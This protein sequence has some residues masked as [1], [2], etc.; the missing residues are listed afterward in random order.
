MSDAL[1]PYEK[2]YVASKA[3][4]SFLGATFHIDTP[5]GEPAF[6]VKQKAFRLRE[7]IEVFRDSSK[8]DKRL[9][10]QA[11]SISDFSS[12]YDVVDPETGESVGGAKRH[13]F[14]S[15]FQDE[16]SLL[17]ETGEVR[18]KCVER[19]GLMIVLRK[20]MPIIPQTYELSWDGQVVGHVRQRFHPFRLIY[21][22][23]FENLGTFDVRHGIGMVV[24]L[25]AI[26]SERD[27]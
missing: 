16:W 6:W 23:E 3:L 5:G 1:V 11:R 8:A 18:G 20:W 2:R 4:F 15:L 10:I 17:D 19:G 12:G 27:G 9:V 7:Q 24:L 26:E 21:D 25:L 22:V 14:K 13:G